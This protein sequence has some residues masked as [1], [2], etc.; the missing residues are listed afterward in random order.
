M[1][2]IKL[3]GTALILSLSVLFSSCSSDDNNSGASNLDTYISASVAGQNFR[4]YSLAGES[5]G[6][7]TRFGGEINI[8]ATSV[9]GTTFQNANTIVINLS[10]I[11]ATGTYQLNSTSDS[12]LAYVDGASQKIFS[13]DDCEG[14][15]GTITVTLLNDQ[16]IEG[17]FTF[18]GKESFECSEQKVVTSGMFR[19][20]F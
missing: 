19:G 9:E 13:T 8:S 7:A 1:K 12:Y 16:K 4:T 20:T 5:T 10:G 17:T 18:T 14:S 15:T 6:I 2:S 3:L 11:T